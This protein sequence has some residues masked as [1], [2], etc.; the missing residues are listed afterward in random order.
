M[1]LYYKCEFCSTLRTMKTSVQARLDEE[2]HA[3]LEVLVRRNGWSTSRAV[4]EGLQ[5]LVRQQSGGA[6]KRMIGIGMFDS[7]IP[8]LGSNK[9]YLEGFGGNSGIA[10]KT[11]SKRKRKAS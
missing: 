2:T 6:A 8:D 5:L 10:R 4:R 1:R 3:A 7:G 11:E 9:K